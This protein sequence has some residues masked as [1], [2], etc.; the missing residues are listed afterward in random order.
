LASKAED[1]DADEAHEDDSAAQAEER[2]SQTP[3]PGEPADA[4]ATRH[5][6]APTPSGSGLLRSLFYLVWLVAAPAAL[7]IAAVKWLKP[8]PRE[9]DVGPIRSFVAEQQV[10][11]TILAF[12]LFAMLIW[13]LRHLLPF[14]AMAGM[15]GRADLP[16]RIRPRFDHAAHLIDEARRIMRQRAA[17]LKNLNAADRQAL[18]GS[19]ETLEGEM[20]ASRFDEDAFIRAHEDAAEI[21]E[22]RLKRWRKSELREYTESIGFAVAVALIL[23]FFVIEAFKIPTGSMIPTLMVGDHIFVAKYAYGPLLPRSDSR[24]YSRLPPKRGD[25]IVFKYPE[26]KAQDFIKRAIALPGDTLEVIDGRPIVNG[27][28]LP[29]CYVGKLDVTLG[30]RGHLYLEYYGDAA[31]LTMFNERQQEGRC[32]QDL[33]CPGGDQ[34]RAQFCGAVQGPYRIMPGE[35]W[36]LGDNRDNSHDSRAWQGGIG[37][38]VPLGNIKGRAMFVWWSWD[39]H[40]GLKFD[41]LAVNV[42]GTPTLPRGAEALEPAL[43]Q[44]LRNRPPLA[45][46]TPPRP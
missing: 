21:V 29:N 16:A 38:G 10:P 3:M 4:P 1:D 6:R 37:A 31:Y 22:R 43:Q 11:A 8:S 14:A 34:C 19:L 40:D 13:R 18:E 44:C 24:L 42:M 35:L 17:E 12:T 20:T 25:V 28:L 30:A 9:Y 32:D 46:T 33:D 7:A 27:L 2:P 15:V 45:E 26:N 41:R 36:V 23:R 39:Q 5:S